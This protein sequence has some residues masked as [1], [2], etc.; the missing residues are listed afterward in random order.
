MFKWF[1][2]LLFK[3]KG[4]KLV[5]DFPKYGKKAV[6]IAAPHTS[7]WDFVYMIAA[8]DIAGIPLH[9]TIKKEWMRWPFKGIFTRMGAIGI[10]RSPK[11]PGDD[12]RSMVEVMK[13]LFDTRDEL[14]LTI[15]AEGTRS[16]REKWKTGFY[17]VAKAANVPIV[18]SYLDYGKRETGMDK[19]IWPGENNFEED[20]REIMSFY[21]TK[22]PKIAEKFSVDLRYID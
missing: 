1:F 5:G 9:F 13:E 11:Q 6:I 2:R 7:N 16:R 22:T 18:C 19:L 20:M 8:F 3:L 15:T 17:Y 4:F 21:A 10:D 12:R 14:V